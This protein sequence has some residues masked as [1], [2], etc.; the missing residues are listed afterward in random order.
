M[1]FHVVHGDGE[2]LG[3]FNESEFRRMIFS[4]E[5]KPD[6]H[7]WHEGLEGWKPISAYR[8]AAKTV[9]L[10]APPPSGPPM[11]TVR[12][13]PLQNPPAKKFGGLG[14]RLASIRRRFSK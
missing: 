9:R 8:V 2:S 3:E 14:E 7:Y 13:A 5:L 11:A 10:T 1:Q 4:G 12:S 6:D